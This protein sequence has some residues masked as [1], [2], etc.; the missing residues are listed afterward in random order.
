MKIKIKLNSPSSTLPKI[1][2]KG[3]WIDLY[4][5]KKVTLHAPTCTDSTI[6]FDTHVVPLGVCMKLPEGFEAV[7]NARSSSFKNWG[8]I[9]SNAQGVID[10][11]YCG[12]DDEWK[13]PIVSFK[14]SVIEVGDRICQFRIQLSQKATFIQKLKWFFSNKI[15]IIQVKELNNS[16]RG[17]FGTTNK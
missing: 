9:L 6:K 1:I 3:D 11:T 2:A 4:S 17:G 15:E 16:N 12:N 5:S 13:C 14:D 10:N 8:F 7:V